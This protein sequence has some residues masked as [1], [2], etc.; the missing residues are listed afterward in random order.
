LIA[1][2]A[3][4]EGCHILHPLLR[5]ALHNHILPKHSQDVLNHHIN[6]KNYRS[7]RQEP[8]GKETDKSFL[9][10][11]P[12]VLKRRLPNGPRWHLQRQPDTLVKDRGRIAK[13]I[14]LFRCPQRERQHL[15][16]CD[17]CVVRTSLSVS[18]MLSAQRMS[19]SDVT[20]NFKLGCALCICSSQSK[21]ACGENENSGTDCRLHSM[22][23]CTVHSI[24]LVLGVLH[25]ILSPFRTPQQSAVS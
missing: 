2:D 9:G 20:S 16:H 23:Y 3:T 17:L 10:I 13:G 25:T 7:Q 15:V 22:S 12:G 11:S 14:R 6:E 1:P 21:R 4:A 18:W 5:H 8:K 24:L 19:E